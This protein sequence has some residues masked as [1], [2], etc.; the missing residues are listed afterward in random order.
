MFN[1]SIKITSVSG[2]NFVV[3][4]FLVFLTFDFFGYSGEHLYLL[5]L[6]YIYI[7]S[8]LLHS[9]FTLKKKFGIK[10]FSLFTKLN[11]ILFFIDYVIFIL[12]KSLFPFVVVSTIFI[13]VFIHTIRIVLFSKEMN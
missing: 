6:F 1:K 9:R 13:T 8:Y 2:I 11:L 3:K 5:I 10:S 7:Q 12:I 4:N